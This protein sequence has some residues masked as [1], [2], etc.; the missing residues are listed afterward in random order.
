MSFHRL[1]AVS[2]LHFSLQM[3]FSCTGVGWQ[4]VSSLSCQHHSRITQ[5]I[6]PSEV[7]T[8]AG[9]PPGEQ[10][11]QIY[12]PAF[13][14]VWIS[15]LIIDLRFSWFLLMKFLCILCIKWAIDIA[16]ENYWLCH[17]LFISFQLVKQYFHH[18]LAVVGWNVCWKWTTARQFYA[19]GRWL[20]LLL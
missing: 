6:C 7:F 2:R 5:E 15:I 13:G 16:K 17:S 9:P 18:I 10:H 20:F 14:Y 19:D 1:G 4:T 3:Y 12:K 8:W 11:I